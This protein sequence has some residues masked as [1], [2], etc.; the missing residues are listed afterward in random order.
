MIYNWDDFVTW[1]KLRF[2]NAEIERSLFAFNQM[3]KNQNA[4][5][6]KINEKF[7]KELESD[8][9]YKSLESTATYYQTFYETEKL[10]I[11][12]LEKQQR[13]SFLLSIFS[14]HELILKKICLKIKLEF[15]LKI[16]KKLSTES[17]FDV[18]YEF[19]TD[20]FK[21]NTSKIETYFTII[22]NQKE[23]R[24]K[25]AHQS[26]YLFENDET[27]IIQI[28]GLTIIEFEDEKYINIDSEYLFNLTENISSFY[29]ELIPAIDERY[30]ILTQN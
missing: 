1:D 23:T 5:L 4:S 20:V 19:L 28:K 3:L 29:K 9:E 13:F 16:R 26:G 24:N 2:V 18:Y 30:K 10:T 11:E 22:N 8:Q 7:N 21:I 15:S 14:F 6:K 17:L 27:K 12:E 25:I